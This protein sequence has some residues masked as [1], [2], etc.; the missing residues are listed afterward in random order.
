VPGGDLLAKA[1]ERSPAIGIAGAT[2]G[3]RRGAEGR[4]GEQRYR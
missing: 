1:T 3:Q 2:A 4:Q